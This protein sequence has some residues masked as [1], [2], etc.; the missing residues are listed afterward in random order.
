MT[1]KK[2]TANI[3]KNLEL[4]LIDQPDDITRLEISHDKIKELAH[5]IKE[6]GQ[7]QPIVVVKRDGRYEIVAGHRR[8]LANQ[9]LKNKIISCKIVDLEP[10]EIALARAMENIQRT[11]LTPV[12]E[13]KIY[14]GL[15]DKF[16]LDYDKIGD[17]TG[18]SGG[19]VK[20]RVKI[21]L[22]PES[23]IDAVH[24]KLINQTVAEEL[25]RCPDHAHREYLIE[26]AKDHGV[27]KEVART[28]V[29]D[30][31]KSIRTGQGSGEQGTLDAGVYVDRP[32]YVTCEL[33]GGPIEVSK[34]RNFTSCPECSKELKRLIESS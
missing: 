30:H 25:V 27:T 6:Q 31:L 32:V 5:S 20:R 4:A 23:L 16:K 3:Y 33:C 29:D 19:V 13:A 24:K 14:K 10:Q 8:Y 22:M 26:M 7:L 34:A 12:E 1:R 15:I 21:L 28:W 17:M 2:T 9:Y 11:D 18:V